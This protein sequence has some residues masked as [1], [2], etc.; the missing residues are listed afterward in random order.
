MA[1][2]C[3]ISEDGYLRLE[4]IIGTQKAVCNTAKRPLKRERKVIYPPLIPVSRSTWLA[5]VKVGRY[6]PPIRLAPRIVVWKAKDVLAL[7]NP[8]EDA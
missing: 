7:L 3:S 8:R 1:N 4:Q 2:N 6:P 5:G